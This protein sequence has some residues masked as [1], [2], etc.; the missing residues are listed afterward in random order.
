MATEQE[1]IQGI[2]E[3]V[4]IPGYAGRIHI[5]N[6]SRAFRA[7][8]E[9]LCSQGQTEM[10]QSFRRMSETIDAVL[11]GTEI[12]TYDPPQDFD[13]HVKS[14]GNHMLLGSHPPDELILEYMT[15]VAMLMYAHIDP[16]KR[17]SVGPILGW[18]LL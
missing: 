7:R 9:T 12:R 6:A 13:G 18:G 8:G 5:R 11:A 4:S 3:G 15:T 2:R 17:I 16:S 1:V 10:A 14:L